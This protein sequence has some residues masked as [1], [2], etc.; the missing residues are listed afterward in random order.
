MNTA[1]KLYPFVV[2]SDSSGT[3]RMQLYKDKTTNKW[4]RVKQQESSP[5]P[6]T[7]TGG[8]TVQGPPS[9]G[10]ISGFVSTVVGE[11]AQKIMR[12]SAVMARTVEAATRI[13]PLPGMAQT[14]QLFHATANL[15]HAVEMGQQVVQNQFLPAIEEMEGILGGTSTTDEQAAAGARQSG[16]QQVSDLQTAIAPQMTSTADTIEG[17]EQAQIPIETEHSPTQQVMFEDEFSDV[18]SV[19]HEM[20]NAVIEELANSDLDEISDIE[21]EEVME[22]TIQT[23]EDFEDYISESQRW[24]PWSSWSGDSEN[25]RMRGGSMGLVTSHGPGQKWKTLTWVVN[26]SFTQSIKEWAQSWEPKGVL[27]VNL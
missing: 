23:L 11:S 16:G 20:N 4:M 15:A 27:N 17:K 13:L 10:M 22:E 24:T 7:S 2:F 14:S 9:R 1:L 25:W 3:L 6:G 26:L 18:S 19:R 5:Q 21:F 8:E 12:T